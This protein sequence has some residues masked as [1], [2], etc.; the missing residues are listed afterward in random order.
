[1]SDTVDK[2]SWWNELGSFFSFSTSSSSSLDSDDLLETLDDELD[3]S[4][5]ELTSGS[6]QSTQ[7]HVI[8]ESG[9]NADRSTNLISDTSD[10]EL[11]LGFGGYDFLSGGPGDDILHGGEERDFFL[12][13]AGIDLVIGSDNP[14]NTS[15][16]DTVGY[17]TATSGIVVESSSGSNPFVYV[18]DDGQGDYDILYAVPNIFGS[19]FDDTIYGRSDTNNILMG[20]IGD[21]VLYGVGGNNILIGGS[22]ADEIHGGSGVDTVLIGPGSDEVSGGGGRDVFKFIATFLTD[23]AS[24]AA[25]ITDFA[26]G[27]SGDTLDVSALLKTVGYEGSN[28]VSDGY[29]SISSS[30]SDTVVKFDADGSGGSSAKTIATLQGVNAGSFSTGSNLVTDSPAFLY[31]PVLGQSN[32]RALRVF[33]GDSESGL[34]RIQDGLESA[35]D[36]DHVEIVPDDNTGNVVDLAVGGSIVVGSEGSKEEY[37]WWYADTWKPGEILMRAVDMMAIQIADLRAQGVTD[38][39]LVWG[40]GESDAHRLG[41]P[42]SESGREAAQQEY[43]DA[44]LAVFDYIKDRLGDDITFYIMQTGRYD[45]DAALRSGESSGH[46]DDVVA[47]LPL[48]H[49]AQEKMAL[50]RDDIL[51]AASYKDLPMRSEV[52]EDKRN[53]SWHYEGEEMEIIGTRIADFIAL[54]LGYTNVIDNPGSYPAHL[55][56]DLDLQPGSGKTV[57]GN[58]EENIVV[59]TDGNDTLDGKGDDDMLFGGEG[60]DTIKGGSGNDTAVFKGRSEDYTVQDHGGGSYTVTD[61]VGNEGTDT[62]TSIETLQFANLEVSDSDGD[63]DDDEI[64]DPDDGDVTPPPP[65]PPPPPSSSSG[66][67]DDGTDGD[68]KLYGGNGNDTIKGRAGDDMIFGGDG[69]DTLWGNEGDDMFFGGLGADWIKGSDG[70]DIYVYEDVLE[71]GDTIVDFRPGS[72][73]KIDVS[74]ILLDAPGFVADDAFDDGFLRVQQSGSHVQVFIDPDGSGGGE[75]ETLLVTLENADAGEIGLDNFILPPDTPDAPAQ[76]DP[77]AVDDNAFGDEDTNITGNVLGNDT[78]PES[79]PLS[80]QPETGKTTAQGGTV[81]ILANGDFTYTPTANFNGADSF[82]YTLLDGQGGSDTGTV[83][84]TV[85]PVNDNPVAYDDEFSGDEDTDVNGNVLAD[86]GNGADS[87]TDGDALGVTPATFASVE[88]GTVVL[89][90]NGNFI[91]SPASGF[92][93]NDSFDYT[94]V[95][96]NGGNDSGTVFI[97]V[98]E[99]NNPPVAVND[100]FS[101]DEDTEINGNVLADNG[102]GADSDPDGDTLNVQAAVLTTSAGAEVILNTNGSFTYTPAD[103]FH[104]TDSFTYTLEDDRGLTDTAVVTL[105]VNPVNDNPDAKDDSFD[106]VEGAPVSGNLLANNGNGADD[107]V[108]GNPLSVTAQTFTTPDGGTVVIEANGDFTYTP[109]GGFTGIDGFDYT[110]LDGQGGNDTGSVTIDIEPDEPESDLN[111]IDGTDDGERL[112]GTTADDALYGYLGDDTLKG[113]EGNDELFGGGGND[114]LWGNDG[115]DFLEGGFGEDW[116]KGGDGAD[117]F[118]FGDGAFDAVDTIADFRPHYGD[119]IELTDLLEGYDPLTDAITDFVRITS[120][121]GDSILSVDANGAD[122]GQNFTQIAVISGVTGLEDEAQLLSDGA[123]MIRGTV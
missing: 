109:A 51:L 45:A 39:A 87:D 71:G 22:G 117:I 19:R 104:G 26:T 74:A 31:V 89:S 79:D 16:K 73:E 103:D 2:P 56:G 14:G 5:D 43:I 58:D 99:V 6:F 68:D 113:R 76:A 67:P 29:V 35:T 88:G 13:G 25:L 50:E 53:D 60:D 17:H 75:G 98:N 36:Y 105:T 96:G 92:I 86:N 12:P 42:G 3:G 91:Y 78:D 34:T 123:L 7:S 122:G 107:D 101:G 11:I 100:E 4:T 10:D 85:N 37:T 15:E 52:N 21:D 20:G 48:I 59:G 38:I 81:T 95:D 106:G 57:N 72:N 111:R 9:S 69:D 77:V 64:E 62:L 84:L 119:V 112:D 49:E 61:N 44:T 30:G 94:L 80:T 27:S 33:D 93:G 55:L 8:K 54:N 28:A 82:T 46:V 23:I 24:N 90:A 108:D 32:A 116:M 102:N 118:A 1:M 63:D 114:T 66:G 97:T 41:E 115:D 70:S 47:G 110:L 83:N 40:Q 121:G 18:S 120:N 65:P